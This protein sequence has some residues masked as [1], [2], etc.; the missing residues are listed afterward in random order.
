M[1]L[2]DQAVGEAEN[3]DFDGCLPRRPESRGQWLEREI[4]PHESLLRNVLQR[5][6]PSVDIDDVIQATYLRLMAMPKVDHVTGAKNY[7][8][9]AATSVVLD[10]M[11]RNRVVEMVSVD[12]EDVDW[13]ADEPTMESIID[14]RRALEQFYEAISKLTPRQRAVVELRRIEGLRARATADRLALSESS[15]EKLQQH[16]LRRLAAAMAEFR[17]S[18][19]NCRGRY[20]RTS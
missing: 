11:R 13:A 2:F 15:V 6:Y 14:S 9:R 19:G 5:K 18:Q 4:I 7:F 20:P 3:E 16:A 17:G 10:R 8:F 12:F 1:L